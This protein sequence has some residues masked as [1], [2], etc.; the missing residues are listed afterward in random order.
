MVVFGILLKIQLLQLNLMVQESEILEQ[1]T[2]WND[3]ASKSSQ[4]TLDNSL[5][6][7]IDIV[8][9]LVDSR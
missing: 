8:I 7:W 1:L 9:V 6:S 5:L 4:L 2:Y 3:L